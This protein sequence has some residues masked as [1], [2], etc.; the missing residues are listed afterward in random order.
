VKSLGTALKAHYASGTTTLATCWKATLTNGTVVAATTLDRDIVIGGVTYQATQGYNASDIESSAELNPDNLEIE[1][2]LASPAITDDDIHSGL[3]DY[4]AIEIFEVNYADLTMGKNVLRVGTLGEVRGSRSKFTAELRGLMQAYT[5]TIVRLVT[6]ECTAD[7]GDARCKV[8][9][10]AIT[11]PGIV[12]SAQENRIFTDAARSEVADWFTGAKLTWMTGANAG[13]SMEVKQSSPGRIELAHSMYEPIMSGD[14]YMVH[15]GCT[16]RFEE[17]CILKHNNGINFRGFPD[18]PGSRIYRQGGVHYGDEVP[19]GGTGGTGGGTGGGD[20]GG[21]GPLIGT[22]W[23]PNWVTGAQPNVQYPE[24]K[25]MYALQV[26]V[27]DVWY[28]TADPANPWSTDPT[29]GTLSHITIRKQY[30]AYGSAFSVGDVVPID[31]IPYGNVT[32]PSKIWTSPLG[33]Q[34]TVFITEGNQ[35]SLEA[36]PNPETYF[37]H[38]VRKVDGET[39]ELWDVVLLSSQDDLDAYLNMPV[40]WTV[41]YVNI[42]ASVAYTPGPYAYT[43]SYDNPYPMSFGGA[44]V[45]AGTNYFGRALQVTIP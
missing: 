8:D 32:P 10:A 22:G 16:K 39:F 14:T 29:Q 15:A 17:D 25:A 42:S 35:W 38:V 33:V 31:R 36:T 43:L 19:A 2:F 5:R 4:A 45:Q 34:K 12:G 6:E 30:S 9:L 37:R 13:R 41:G 7:L 44:A 28:S 26:T 40:E 18:L 23:T 11:V 24:T 20:S 3:W 27:G 1:G 21:G